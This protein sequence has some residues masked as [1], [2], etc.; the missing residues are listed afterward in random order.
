MWVAGVSGLSLRLLGGWLHIHGLIRHHTRTVAGR[1]ME[2]LERLKGRMRIRGTVRL[3]ESIQVQVPMAVGWLRP[4]IL[5]PATALTGLPPDQIEAILAHELAHIGRYDYLVNLV[6]SMVETLLFYHPAAWWISGR[7]RVEREHCCD[8]RAVEICGDRVLYARALA[9]LEERRG[10]S[11]LLAVS[12]RDGTLLERI[13]RLLGVSAPEKRAAGGLAG[14]LALAVVSVLGAVI[15]L[16]PATS[17]ARAG[18]EPGEAI[19]GTVVAA[20]GRPVAGAKVWLV[21][22]SLVEN[23]GFILG[24]SRTDGG[25][26]FRLIP[27]EEPLKRGHLGWAHSGLTS[28]ASNWRRSSRGTISSPSVSIRPGPSR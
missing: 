8:D 6:Q 13:R 11:W 7:I 27:M 9:A 4:V 12:A 10:A 2:G 14:T 28:R 5:L 1:G 18:V 26:R 17:Q 21:A 24:K 16:A 25:G 23:S 3:L 19:A 20:D 15:L 22:H